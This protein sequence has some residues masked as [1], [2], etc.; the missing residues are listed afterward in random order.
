MTHFADLPDFVLGPLA[1]RP[2]AD[3]YKA[4]AGKWNAAQIVEHLALGLE[5]SAKGFEERRA[6]D[7]MVRQ[8]LGFVQRVTKVCV[9]GLGWFPLPAEAPARAVPGPQVERAAVEAHYRRGVERNLELAQLLL[10]ARARDLFVTHQRMGDLTLS[11]WMTFHVR[12]A[13]HHVKQIRERMA[14]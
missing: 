7:P 3:W 11:E 1:K 9:M 8:P 14:G 6:R 4:P 12:H 10:P 2:D 13:R 5:W